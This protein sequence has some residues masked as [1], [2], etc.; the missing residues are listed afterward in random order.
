MKLTEI[1]SVLVRSVA[2]TSEQFRWRKKMR[3][4]GTMPPSQWTISHPAQCLLFCATSFPSDSVRREF[5]VSLKIRNWKATRHCLYGISAI[6]ALYFNVKLHLDPNLSTS[7]FHAQEFLLYIFTIAGAILAD[8]FLGHFKTIIVMQLVYAV[9]A[10]VIAVGNVEP[11]N[12]S[13]P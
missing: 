12:L 5:L 6:L 10:T 2:G 4:V 9:G 3:K 1:H 13:L 11:L 7:V 8:S